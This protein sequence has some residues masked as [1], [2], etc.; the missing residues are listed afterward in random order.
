MP[1]VNSTLKLFNNRFKLESARVILSRCPLNLNENRELEDHCMFT[2]GVLPMVLREQ[3]D[4]L[5]T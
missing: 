2:S 1:A 5:Q 3:N 4:I